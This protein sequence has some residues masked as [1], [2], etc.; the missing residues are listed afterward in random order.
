MSVNKINLENT[1]YN[2][3]SVLK[4]L[5]TVLNN[6]VIKFTSIANSFEITTTSPTSRE[7]AAVYI[8]ARKGMSNYLTYPHFDYEV[9]SKAGFSDTEIQNI[10][11]YRDIP[12][13]RLN[14]CITLQDEVTI[15]NY[16]ERNEYYRI[17]MGLPRLDEEEFIFAPDE[18]YIELGIPKVPVHELTDTQIG[19]MEGKG[20][21]ENIQI[22][23]PTKEYLKFLGYYKLDLVVMRE[24]RNFSFLYSVQGKVN[25]FLYE[26]F[27]KIYETTREYFVSILYNKDIA[28]YTPGY[29][30][31]MAM[32]IMISTI[33]RLF[34]STFSFITERNFFD[35]RSMK[36]FYDAYNVPYIEKLPFDY[37]KN[38]TRNL[39]YLLQNKS[40]AKCMVEIFKILNSE[41][42]GLYR[43]YLIKQQKMDDHQNPQFI[44]KLDDDGNPTSELDLENMYEFYFQMVNIEERNLAMAFNDTTMKESYESLTQNDPYWIEDAY[45]REKLI[46]SN[47]NFLETKYLGVSIMYKM[48]EILFEV[49]YAL[50]LITDKK[51]EVKKLNVQIYKLFTETQFDLFSVLAFLCAL[52]CKKQG[53]AGNI[54]YDPI[55]VTSVFGLRLTDEMLKVKDECMKNPLI[56]PKLKNYLKDLAVNDRDDLNRI[57]MEIKE[58]RRLV[59]FNMYYAKS[60]PEYDLYEKMMRVILITEENRTAYM[61]SDGIPADTFLDYLLLEEPKLGNYVRTV[62]PEDIVDSIDSTITSISQFLPDL[63]YLFSVNDGNS[64][65]IDAIVKLISFFK[66]YTTDV[67]RLS[68]NFLF[69][70]SEDNRIKFIDVMK[71]DNV[72]GPGITCYT[73]SYLDTSYGYMRINSEL[74]LKDKPDTFLKDSINIIHD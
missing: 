6:M 36:L 20:I 16:V 2:L 65:I 37:H 60:K 53:F 43:Y 42:M 44:Y 26:E 46:N 70:N 10:R 48:S 47:A 19:I 30:N 55:K 54:L 27:L 62:L 21:L 40:T 39:N 1:G 15:A 73:N 7:E 11:S 58:F 5:E 4:D 63:E 50:N 28:N 74:T 23:N 64:V 29:D 35:L 14:T 25:D 8:S 34:N 32:A 13:D 51:E 66:S 18:F 67:A 45:L 12:K 49:Q 69:N 24:S 52:V 9:L 41:S 61:K 56:D 31:F 33:E 68:M 22:T 17:Y 59:Q 57:M 3:D 72:S 38:L 71:T